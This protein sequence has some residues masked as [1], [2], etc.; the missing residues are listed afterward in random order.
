MH[1]IKYAFKDIGRERIKKNVN[2]MVFKDH[3]TFKVMNDHRVETGTLPML[4]LRIHTIQIIGVA[5]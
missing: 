4:M 3:K 5:I 2:V 1:E